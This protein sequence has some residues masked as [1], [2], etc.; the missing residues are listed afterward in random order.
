MLDMLG[1]LIAVSESQDP[2]RPVSAQH[3][4]EPGAGP[5][6][7][8]QSRARISELQTRGYLIASDRLTAGSYVTESGHAAWNA[9]RDLRA[10]RATRRRQMRNEYLAWIYTQSEEGHGHSPVSSDFLTSGASFYGADYTADDLER[11]GAWLEE[12]G[13]IRGAGSWGGGGPIRPDITA[14]GSR[15]VEDG[16]DVHTPPE[17]FHR[18]AAAPQ[19]NVTLA[20]GASANIAQGSSDVSQTLNV[21]WQGD[22]LALIEA[23]DAR[24]Q[25][26]HDT[27]EF[28]ELRAAMEELRDAATSEAEPGKVRRIAG[29]ITSALATAAAAQLG[30]DLMQQSIE[31]LTSMS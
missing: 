28:E 10:N 23:I 30:T 19:Y 15:Y 16:I 26:V 6:E 1:R 24:L 20:S 22:A 13:F 4:I 3:G 14:K 9:L 21:G 31:F 18:G 25:D 27:P 8:D 11:V 7:Q 29:K 2:P 17:A 5:G 12:N